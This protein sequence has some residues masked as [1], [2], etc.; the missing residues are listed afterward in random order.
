M[1]TPH[2]MADVRRPNRSEIDCFDFDY[3]MLNNLDLLSQ[4]ST[5]H[6]PQHYANHE[7]SV[8]TSNTFAK[9]AFAS[10]HW[11]IYSVFGVCW[12]VNHETRHLYNLLARTKRI[13][14]SYIYIYILYIVATRSPLSPLHDLFVRDSQM[15]DGLYTVWCVSDIYYV[16]IVDYNVR[17]RSAWL[18]VACVLLIRLYLPRKRSIYTRRRHQ[19]THHR[20]RALSR[21]D[22]RC[23]G[24]CRRMM[25]VVGKSDWWCAIWPR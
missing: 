13:A 20:T 4:Q 16:R 25:E 2:L 15:D 12:G 10:A 18:L 3:I 9:L 7:W 23:A 1:L 11:I 8:C 14:H 21:Q 17:I 19:G 22:V 5:W 24:I 6:A